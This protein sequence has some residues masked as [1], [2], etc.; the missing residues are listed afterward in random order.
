MR[1]ITVSIV[2][3]M[4]SPA[5]A[6]NGQGGLKGGAGQSQDALGVGSV[7]MNVAGGNVQRVEAAT[8][9]NGKTVYLPSNAVA[10]GLNVA[11]AAS[12][13]GSGGGTSSGGVSSAGG[14]GGGGGGAGGLVVDPALIE[15]ALEVPDGLGA[16]DGEV[17]LD[18]SGEIEDM[19]PIPVPATL[20]LLGLALA[21]LP[22]AARRRSR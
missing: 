1:L 4:A 2:A 18:E 9:G 16:I 6:A 14:M 22:F 15:M 17:E 3:L 10:K 7:P 8:P 5:L 13:S 19:A 11:A 12:G 21:A 20:P